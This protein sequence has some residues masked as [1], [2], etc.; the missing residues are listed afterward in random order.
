MRGRNVEVKI[1]KPLNCLTRMPDYVAKQMRKVNRE[2]GY[3]NQTQA[4]YFPI[5]LLNISQSL[6]KPKP[7]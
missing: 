1:Q 3:W 7:K 4:N 6:V 5:R 2:K